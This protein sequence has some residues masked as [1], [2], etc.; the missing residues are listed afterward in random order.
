MHRNSNVMGRECLVQSL[1]SL[2]I[3]PTFSIGY[4]G[5]S[6]IIAFVTLATLVS[7]GGH[8]LLATRE[9]SII[10]LALIAGNEPTLGLI[11]VVNDIDLKSMVF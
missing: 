7:K 5:T 9:F 3:L 8:C 10:H 4:L 11:S 2:T 6:T 1:L